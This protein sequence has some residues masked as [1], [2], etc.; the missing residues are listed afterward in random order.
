[1]VES[2]QE[3][4]YEIEGKPVVRTLIFSRL[5]PDDRFNGNFYPFVG[6]PSLITVNTEEAVEVYPFVKALN[7]TESPF[8][9]W[10]GFGKMGNYDFYRVCLESPKIDSNGSNSCVPL[11]SLHLS[12][13][14]PFDPIKAYQLF[15][16][17]KY[18]LSQSNPYTQPQIKALGIFSMQII[19]IPPNLDDVVSTL[20][21]ISMPFT[22][23]SLLKPIKRG[24]YQ[25]S[26]VVKKA[27]GREESLASSIYDAASG[28]LR[29]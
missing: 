22:L 18:S 8:N 25:P 1:M 26:E 11:D 7:G 29:L 16:I 4:V 15:D 2:L 28:L 3:K 14:K 5:G 21:E 23:Q 13:G 27:L 19:H 24:L 20:Q 6:F 12:N 10:L 9:Q 17:L